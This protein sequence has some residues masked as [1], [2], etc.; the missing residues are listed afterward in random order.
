ME[1]L[2]SDVEDIETIRT[3]KRRRWLLIAALL[4]ALAGFVLLLTRCNASPAP[5]PASPAAASPAAPLQAPD[6]PFADE[7][8]GLFVAF[9]D[10]GQ[11]DCIF[12]RAPDGRTML[13]DSGPAGSFGVIKRFLDVRGVRRLDMVV[14][15]HMH[16][17]HIGSM[18]EVVEHYEV[19]AFYISPFDIESSTYARLLE[20]LEH[21]GVAAVPVYAS[22]STVLPWSDASDT[23]VRVLAPYDVLYEDENDTSVMLRVRFGSTAVLLTGDATELSE[24]LAV[25]AQHNAH[26]HSD[27]LKV[28]HHGSNSSTS[29]KFLSAVKPS[30]A[31]ISLGKSNDYDHPSQA[32]LNR[33]SE[34]NV[35]VLR[36]DELGTV[37]I[38]LDGTNVQVIE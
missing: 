22:A 36:T 17:D 38:L 30:I 16:E 20:A 24:R 15:T 19:G 11:G 8:G 2:F 13:V 10:V 32:V 26:L 21:E 33:L 5:A 6:E 3:R 28:G 14:A 18:R 27:V 9:L 29:R 34:A 37:R 25:K 23:E 1:E 12:L 31:V 4:V 7:T 35:R